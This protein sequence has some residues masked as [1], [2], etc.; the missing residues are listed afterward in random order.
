MLDRI[1]SYRWLIVALLAIP[2]VA[3]SVLLFS[4]RSSNDVPPLVLNANEEPSADIRVYITGAVANPGVYSLEPG[5]RW[6]DAL[7]AAGGPTA[8]AAL[9]SINL[10][11]RAEDE[12]MIVVPAIGD[13]AV[14]APTAPS[15]G[16]VNINTASEDELDTLPGIGEV[17]ASG[18]VAS[19]QA[20][21]PFT[22]I[23][24]LLVRELVPESVFEDIS[25]LITV[26]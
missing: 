11:L 4:E 8:D 2:V 15:N 10:S 20:D 23:D 24:D 7:E 6:I 26:N 16:V 12:D 5:L 1:E 13:A 14:S 3:G 22:S 21:G 19:R 9:G 25:P 18:I 17:R